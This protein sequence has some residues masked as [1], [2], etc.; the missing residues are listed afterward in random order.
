MQRAL[1][2]I[3]VLSSDLIDKIAAG[4]VV[5]R[6][7]SVVKELC[8]NS[9]DAQAG[10][11][12]ITLSEGGLSFISVRDDGHGMGRSDAELAVKRHATS[13]LKT[14]DDLFCI[15]SLGFRGEALPSISSI[16]RFSLTTSLKGASVGTRLRSD[17]G[18]V[19]KIEDAP[20]L[21]GTL[22]EVGELFFNTPARRK[23]MRRV[24]TELSNVKEAV[25]RIALSHPEVG[26]Q[27]EHHGRS[28]FS[29]DACK[30]D[31]KERII[32]AMGVQLDRHLL[33]L[34]GQQLGIKVTGYVSAPE[35]TYPNAR[36]I[37]TYV[38]RRFIR[39]KHLN[40]ALSRAFRDC[41]PPGRYPMA[42][43]FIEV[44]PEDVDVNVH[45]QKMEVRFADGA[46][47][48]DVLS[49]AVRASLDK[50]PWMEKGADGDRS[51]AQDALYAQAVNQFLN[52]SR[53]VHTPHLDARPVPIAAEPVSFGLP[54]HYCSSLRFICQLGTRFW[55]CKGRGDTLVILDGDAAVQLHALHQLW[56]EV[57]RAP[58]E[59]V[60]FLA[61]ASR[62]ELGTQPHCDPREKSRALGQ[63]G[64]ELE[65]FGGTSWVVLRAPLALAGTDLENLFAELLPSLP[66]DASADARPPSDNLSLNELLGALKIVAKHRVRQEAIPPTEIERLLCHMDRA[67]EECPGAYHLV[68][69]EVPLL[70]LERRVLTD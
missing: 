65:S 15:R 39:D 10:E 54:A 26:F 27:L 70:E 47:V 66:S 6:P 1:Q 64:F 46:G 41:L 59:G 36:Y 34:E 61:N 69:M 28:L 12:Q 22:I 9:L 63:V 43:V 52:Q 56:Q 3:E 35:Q 31:I 51:S 13:K 17:G 18:V 37:Y 25:I 23:F 33:P 32:A 50:A 29:S 49:R 11:I 21:N 4:E 48:C 8:E 30:G 42:V 2:R 58:S 67:V 19:W 24:Q 62:V 60:A 45:P 68:V 5:E 14:L 40:H 16:S 57:R 20:P 38:N 53:Q 7:A 55:L 44:D